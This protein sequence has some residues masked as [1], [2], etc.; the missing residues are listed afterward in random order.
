MKQLYILPQ[1]GFDS[2]I[3]AG[4]QK[5]ALE[6]LEAG[7]VLHFPAMAF[8]LAQ[9]ES[10]F[11]DPAILSRS[12]NVGYH[13]TTRK[14]SGTECQGVDADD[15]KALLARYAD[16]AQGMLR[17]LL[18]HYGTA[19]RRERTSLRPAIV[20]GRVTSWR[21]DDSRLHVDSF[22]SQPTQGRRLLRLFCNVNPHGR[23]RVW[24]VGEPFE[25]MA[26]RFWPRLTRPVWINRQILAWLRVTKEFRSDYDHY[27]LQLHDGMKLDQ[28]YQREVD[29]A[30][31]PFP[32]GSSWACFTDQV[33]HAALSGQHQFEQT[34]TL[35]VEA[36][37]NPAT[38][39]LA[40]LEKLAGRDLTERAHR[41]A[42]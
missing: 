1:V 32:A 24:R 31:V 42:A 9:A 26:A 8:P 29:Q 12:K 2:P 39:P 6:A 14:L 36:H 10:R 13:P 7:R 40:V 38:S 21:K 17:R 35:P 22:P 27:M 19:L 28:A 37:L 18:A 41:K 4:L 3:P 25:M 30:T 5:E 20:E 23:P 11:L 34:F 33:S 16:T 15:L